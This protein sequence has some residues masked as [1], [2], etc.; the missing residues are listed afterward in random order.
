MYSMHP[1]KFVI[2]LLVFRSNT[3]KLALFRGAVSAI[4][5]SEASLTVTRAGARHAACGVR[6]CAPR[7]DTRA[8]LTLTGLPARRAALTQAAHSGR[9]ARDYTRH[10]AHGMH[11]LVLVLAAALL[12][13]AAA[14]RA[15]TDFEFDDDAV[16]H[17]ALCYRRWMR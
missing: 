16:R 6:Q 5:H 3:D 13:A 12:G 15:D 1:R 4:R 7:R 9:Q 14:R 11:R 8:R 10:T 17:P 2:K